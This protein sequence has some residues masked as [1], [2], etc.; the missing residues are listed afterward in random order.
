MKDVKE[1]IAYLEAMRWRNSSEFG[2]K[3]ENYSHFPPLS[4]R[5]EQAARRLQRGFRLMLGR[6]FRKGQ[7]F[8]YFVACHVIQRA[9]RRVAPI[10]R[11]QKYAAATTIQRHWRGRV[12]RKRA[13]LVESYGEQ[14]EVLDGFATWL[15]TAA[16]RRAA[17]NLV[18]QMRK[19]QR[20]ESVTGVQGYPRGTHGRTIA[21]HQAAD[22]EGEQEE[23][24]EE[25]EEKEHKDEYAG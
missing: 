14:P 12:G 18:K 23:E 20:K 17:Q 22:A 6:K 13:Q 9:F 5:A 19:N 15:A 1:R 2:S 10:I 11:R 3:D 25:E 4:W 8:E 7:K 24:E 21:R 16:R